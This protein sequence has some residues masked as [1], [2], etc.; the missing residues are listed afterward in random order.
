[1]DA[2]DDHESGKHAHRDLRV[3]AEGETE[4]EGRERVVEGGKWC[5]ARGNDPERA[6]HMKHCSLIGVMQVQ[7]ECLADG[8]DAPDPTTIQYLLAKSYAQTI[9]FLRVNQMSPARKVATITPPK[10]V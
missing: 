10:T 8:A 5:V 6:D 9:T 3:V 4:R 2:A 1:M 7:A